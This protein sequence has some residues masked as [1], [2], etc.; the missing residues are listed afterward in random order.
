MQLSHT[1]VIE[2]LGPGVMIRK[3]FWMMVSSMGL[4]AGAMIPCEDMQRFISELPKSLRK[5][6]K[7][8]MLRLNKEGYV[9]SIDGGG[10][11]LNEIP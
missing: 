6:Y 9:K 3:R 1:F 11:F 10:I 5:N 2:E 4:E 8:S 7:T